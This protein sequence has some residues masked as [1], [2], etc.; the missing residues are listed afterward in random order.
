MAVG[1]S[2]TAYYHMTIGGSM[3]VCGS[4]WL[5]AD[6]FYSFYIVLAIIRGFGTISS[7]RSAQETLDLC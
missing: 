6:N 2:L 3:A 4:G 7:F 1:K 5:E